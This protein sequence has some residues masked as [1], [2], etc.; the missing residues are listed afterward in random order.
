MK[1]KVLMIIGAVVFLL[2]AVVVIGFHYLYDNGLSGQ[3]ANTDVKEGQIKV[4]CVGDSITYGHGVEN[5]EENNLS[6]VPPC[7]IQWSF[8]AFRQEKTVF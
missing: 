1:K 4:A 5:W 8:P 3:Y 2:V 6:A 7:P